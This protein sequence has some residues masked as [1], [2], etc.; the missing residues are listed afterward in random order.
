MTL[1]ANL[2]HTKNIGIWKGKISYVNVEVIWKNSGSKSMSQSSDCNGEG[3]RTPIPLKF[4]YIIF[5]AH[6]YVKSK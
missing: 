2:H 1:K 5:Y 3:W 4:L 6:L